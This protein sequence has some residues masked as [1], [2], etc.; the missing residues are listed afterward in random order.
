V[1]IGL[2][3]LASAYPGAGGPY[4][5]TFMVASEK[6]RKFLVIPFIINITVNL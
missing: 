1:C 5:W 2:A 3:E 4:H 6:N